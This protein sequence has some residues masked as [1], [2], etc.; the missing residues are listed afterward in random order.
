MGAECDW[1][2]GAEILGPANLRDTI[3]RAYDR[4]SRGGDLCLDAKDAGLG[5]GVAFGQ[6]RSGPRL[7]TRTAGT[8]SRPRRVIRSQGSWTASFDVMAARFG[9]GPSDSYAVLGDL[10][11]SLSF[12][13]LA[14]A[15]HLGASV[16]VLSGMAPRA[17]ADRLSKAGNTVVYATPTQVRALDHALAPDLRFTTIRR[18]FIG[19]GPFDGAAGRALLRRFPAA[20][21]ALFYGTS[22]TSFLTLGR[23]A[24]DGAASLFPGVDMKI[25]PDS[26]EV[27]AGGPYIAL[28]YG[29]GDA[30]AGDAP[31]LD[32]C[33]RISLRETG[34]RLPDGRVRL[35]GRGADMVTVADRNV[36][37]AAVEHWLLAQDGI[38]HAAVLP[39]RDALRGNRLEAAICWTG[40]DLGRLRADLRMAL[41]PEATPARLV[42]LAE[43]PL[44]PSGKTD[45]SRIRAALD[46]P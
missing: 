46:L 41:G 16:H 11:H 36:F 4:A 34:A 33:G 40:S 5:L 37:P 9:I 8:T 12:Y 45:M 43:W 6:A 26:G 15:F 30:A 14:E 19:G 17:V 22:E 44:L 3:A 25:D 28:G 23:P 27:W 18:L 7:I 21:A 38:G 31:R 32:A 39:R 35:F 2:A 10:S 20:E 24:Q 29:I 13:A 42:P 1:R